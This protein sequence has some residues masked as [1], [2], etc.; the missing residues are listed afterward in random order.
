MGDIGIVRQGLGKVALIVL[1]LGRHLLSYTMAAL[2]S[3]T[4]KTI[5]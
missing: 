1:V 5:D 2:M 3:H 4:I